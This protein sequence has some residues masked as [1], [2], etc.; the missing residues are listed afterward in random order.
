MDKHPKD[1][2]IPN[3]G[4]DSDI[5]STLKNYASAGGKLA[6]KSSIPACNSADFPG[7]LAAETAADHKLQ[8]DMDK[9]PKDYFIPNFGVD[10]EIITT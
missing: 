10:H 2:F 6:Q 3:F 7:C 9:H 4:V 1:Y 8:K 5:K